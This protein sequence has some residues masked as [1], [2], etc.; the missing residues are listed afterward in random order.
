MN[1][2]RGGRGRRRQAGRAGGSRLSPLFVFI[3][4]AETVLALYLALLVFTRVDG[5]LLPGNEL[6]VGILNNVPGVGGSEVEGGRINVLLVGVDRRPEDGDEPTRTDTIVVATLDTVTKTGAI[7]GIPR[8]LYVAIPLDPNDPFMERINTAYVYGELYDY[9][10]GGIAL[11]EATIERNLGIPIDQYVMVDFLAFER[12]I[13]DL[14]GIDIEAEKEIYYANYSNDDVH[15]RELYIPAGWQ[16]MDGYT[17][18]AYARFRND[19]EGDLGRIRRQQQVMMAA[20]EKAL[21]LGWLDRAPALWNSYRN[22]IVTDVSTARI[23]GYALLAKQ[24]DLDALE[25]RSLGEQVNG[26]FAVRNCSTAQGAS[27]LCP[28][29]DVVDIIIRQV[30]LDPRVKQEAATVEVR[31][32]TGDPFLA[33]R[34]AAY[35]VAQGLPQEAVNAGGVVGQAGETII[36]V[37]NGKEQTGRAIAEWLGVPASRVVKG[38][39]QVPAADVVVVLGPDATIPEED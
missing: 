30:F 4:S 39:G 16:H 27:V 3:L 15:G 26:Q 7:L 2:A 37:Y 12:L 31:N 19:E 32:G 8:D 25:H 24:V 20:A 36:Y 5:V 38:G 22:A 13:D 21:A 23:P 1:A 10:G 11:L 33:D 34:A 17:A 35:L 9:P 14:G 18:L 28:N 29:W 6:N